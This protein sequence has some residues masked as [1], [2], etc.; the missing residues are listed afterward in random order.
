M[1][2]IA[3]VFATSLAA[4]P[5]TAA[6]PVTVE[7]RV[8]MMGTTADLALVAADREK[9]LAASEAVVDELSRVEALLT[10]WRPGG[11]LARLNAEHAGQALRLD[12]ELFSVLSEVF[13]WS[14]RT[15]GAFDPTVAPLIGA[16][17]LRGAGRIPSSKELAAAR[18]ASGVSR[19][20]LDPSTGAAAR[21]DPEAGIDEGAWGKGYALDCASRRL[22]STGVRDALVDLGGQVLARGARSEGEPWTIAIAHPR[23]RQR[24]VVILAIENGSVSTSGDSERRR[25]VHGRSIGH[26]LDPHTG[27]PAP[28]FGSATVVAPSGLAADVLSTAFFVLGPEKG[29]ALSEKLRREGVPNEV[30]FLIDRGSDTLDAVASPGISPLVVSTD[31]RAVHGLPITHH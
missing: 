7:R 19:F 17:G 25:I 16:W 23:D 12:A 1:L 15:E 3:L 24:A 4:A 28:D 5:G 13:A 10:T 27:E 2:T 18:H 6:G 22:E 31:S 8:A 14:G 20:Q 11:P 30:L 21:L 29:L 26:L 9:G